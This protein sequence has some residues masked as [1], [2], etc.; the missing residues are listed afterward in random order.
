MTNFK[1]V[2]AG[3]FAALTATACAGQTPMVNSAMTVEQKQEQ[4]VENV[5]AIPE[6]FLE[7]PAE[8]DNIVYSSG[9]SVMPDLQLSLDI[10]RL[11]AKE[12]LADR[13]SSKLR[14]QTKQYISKV[15]NDDLSSSVLQEIEKATRNLIA[16]V[17]VAG[18]V[19]DKVVVVP[20]GTQYRS[21]VLLKYDSDVAQRMMNN[22]ALSIMQE[23]LPSTAEEAF[24]E[25][26]KA[27]KDLSR[28][29]DAD[30]NNDDSVV[31]RE[32]VTPTQEPKV[33]SP[34]PSFL[35]K[36]PKLPNL[37][38]VFTAPTPPVSTENI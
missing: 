5:S 29:D 8:T 17:E 31:L 19:Q 22:R 36:L 6:W 26:D 12:L 9:T 2:G 4:V 15:G 32:E 21:Y 38:N 3:L 33:A 13:L 20:H 1:I 16:D 24:D 30:E 11:N 34:A 35:D 23:E 10:A 25:M 7:M 28:A 18:Y 14:A 27:I 37:P